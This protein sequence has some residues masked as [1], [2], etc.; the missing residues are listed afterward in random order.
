MPLKALRALHR[1]YERQAPIAF[2]LAG[3]LF[4]AL[5]LTRID[6]PLVILQQALYLALASILVAVEVRELKAPVA[7]PALLAMPWRYRE[8][9]LHFIL[10]SLLNSY[11]IFYFKSSSALTSFLFVVI[12]MALLIINEFMRYGSARAR[13]HVAFLGLCAVSFLVSLTPIVLGFIGVVPFLAANAA[14]AALFY[15]YH[16]WLKADV[17]LV[18][19][20]LAITQ[21]V[22]ALLYFLQVIPPVPLSVTY[23]GIF[24]DVRKK[25]GGY[26]L[27][28]TRSRW[29]FWQ[30]GDQT[31]EARPGDVIHCFAQVFSPSGF[32]DQLQVRWLH[33]HERLGWQ[34]SDAI[35]LAI[36]GGRSEGF[37]GVTK[38]SN[39][40]P[41]RW[42]VQVET[43][44]GRE[45]GRISF[46][47]VQDPDEGPR[48]EKTKAL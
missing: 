15:G 33:H 24:H 32:K 27:V 37:R 19:R 16:R 4:D 43:R 42:R 1:K 9:F 34:S 23:M 41:G 13:V 20:P 40:Q 36:V 35:P 7:M 38:K 6:D 21:A 12:L 14:A 29:K 44:D 18:A 47:V 10:G 46:T 48:E 8:E 3:F 25:D 30:S 45:V 5:T 31:F 39:Y 26:E 22:F 2:F 17:K 11:A 28:Y